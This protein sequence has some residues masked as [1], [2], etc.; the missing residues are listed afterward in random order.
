MLAKEL[1]DLR[2]LGS[3]LAQA[4]IPPHLAGLPKCLH[5]YGPLFQPQL[6]EH[7]AAGEATAA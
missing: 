5:K 1:R 3:P 7:A 6:E 4:A 2:Q